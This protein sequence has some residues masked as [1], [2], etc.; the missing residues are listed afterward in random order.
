[1]DVYDCQ[2]VT[3]TGV[4]EVLTRNAE[5]KGS[6]TEG[7]EIINLKCFYGWQ[8]TVEEHTKRVLRGDNVAA[9]RLKNRW[10]DFVMLSEEASVGGIAGRRRRRRREAEA[11]GLETEGGFPVPRRR[12]RSG[13]CTVM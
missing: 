3:W 2:N 1:M 10:A 7:T 4:C 11:A 5:I 12:A 13:V 8:P 9:S 6:L